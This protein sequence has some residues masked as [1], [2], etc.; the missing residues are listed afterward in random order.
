MKSRLI[1]FDKW[2]TS[3]Y[4][5]AQSINAE[6]SISRDVA[7][8][9][10]GEAYTIIIKYK[11]SFFN[12]IIILQNGSGSRFEVV[13]QIIKYT[14][15]NKQLLDF[16]LSLY[17]KGFLDKLF[18]SSNVKTGDKTFDN[19]FGISTTNKIIASAIFSD[20]DIRELFLNNRFLVF[21]IRKKESTAFFKSMELKLYK[22]EEMQLL[23]DK[24][25]RILQIIREYSKENN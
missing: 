21:N 9:T 11:D 13:P 7:M 19:K 24:F 20:R 12:P 14:F 3:L 2:K 23:L 16:N 22:K 15:T 4:N 1:E 18:I 8:G 6:F 5:W 10:M 17:K 25:V